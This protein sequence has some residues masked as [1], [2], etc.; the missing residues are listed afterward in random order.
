MASRSA[1]SNQALRPET[2]KRPGVFYAFTRDGVEFPVVDVTH[3]AFAISITDSEQQTLVEKFL[4]DGVP[5]AKL[6]RSLRE[7]AL[8]FLLRQSVLA[9][10]IDQARGSL[11]S[12]M[13]TYM[14][15]RPGNVGQLL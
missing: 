3:P 6:L 2:N 10:G 11:M 7:L 12:G 14:L 1:V 9:Q 15:N 8:R 5:L 4:R 13:Q